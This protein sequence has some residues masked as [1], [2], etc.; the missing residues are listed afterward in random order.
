MSTFS[1][2]IAAAATPVDADG[3]IDLQRLAAHCRWLLEAGGCDGVNLLGT[4][5]EA[6]SFS[7]QQ[8]LA[9]MSAVASS[10]L[11]M[12]RLM[13]GT[14]AAALADALALTKAA[15]DLGFAGALLVPPFYYK[16]IGDDAVQ[17]YVQTL[18]DEA[19]LKQ[20]KLYLYHIPQFSGVP[21]SIDVVEQL[22]RRNS[23]VLRGVKDSSGDLTYSKELARRLP[24]IDV[25]PSSEG[26]LSSADEHGFAGCI[27]AT[28][29]V[30]GA[31]AQDA[32]RARGTDAGRKA[33]AKALAIRDAISQFALVPAVKW[34]VS[35]THDDPSWQRVQPPLAALDSDQGNALETALEKLR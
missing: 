31:V 18:I 9:A 5:G 22:A 16:G 4:T 20:A 21:Y 1:G 29:N 26:T 6:T 28:T 8:R 30:N 10:G 33:G 15:D 11:P 27:S 34:G 32:W 2:V 14:G 24:E 17:R 35:L 3:Q 7:V 12:S 19:G 13:V 25:F 23:H